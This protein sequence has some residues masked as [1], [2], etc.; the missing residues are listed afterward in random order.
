MSGEI[1]PLGIAGIP[2][3]RV[4]KA[5]MTRN[6]ASSPGREDHLRVALEKRDGEIWARPILGKS[7]LITTLVKAH[8]TVV[9]PLAKL[10]LEKGE[11]V[12]VKLFE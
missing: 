9:I 7:G 1:D 11:W 6:Y 3:V 2:P 10:G 4:V 12:E 5:R 8:G